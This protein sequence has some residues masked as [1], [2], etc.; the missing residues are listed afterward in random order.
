MPLLEAQQHRT[1]DVLGT[2]GGWEGELV[3]MGLII[4]VLDRFSL[5][6]GLPA[7]CLCR[8]LWFISWTPPAPTWSVFS[9]SLKPQVFPK[10]Y[11][12]API[13]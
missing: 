1:E 4:A 12:K 3:V 8:P 13:L 10:L 11:S 9:L 5:H 6:D 2:N 7:F